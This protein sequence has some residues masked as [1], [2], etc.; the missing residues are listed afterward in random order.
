DATDPRLARVTS[1]RPPPPATS[2]SA[3]LRA[4]LRT[5]PRSELHEQR[6]SRAR[7]LGDPEDHSGERLPCP[8]QSRLGTVTRLPMP[9]C[10]QGPE[11]RHTGAWRVSAVVGLPLLAGTHCR[12]SA[13]E[14]S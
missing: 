9:P 8:R 7:V 6:P 1:G 12:D 5:P 14:V 4:R 13:R 2:P 3:R 11:L 10:H